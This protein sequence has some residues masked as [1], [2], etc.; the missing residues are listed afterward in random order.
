MCCLQGGVCSSSAVVI[1]RYDCRSR[2]YVHISLDILRL[3]LPICLGTIRVICPSVLGFS[4]VT[5][6]LH[7]NMITLPIHQCAIL[8]LEYLNKEPNLVVLTVAGTSSAQDVKQM[9][10]R[11]EK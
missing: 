4:C 7:R 10:V 6:K 1:R 5:L 9:N 11:Q 2:T 8:V 3:T